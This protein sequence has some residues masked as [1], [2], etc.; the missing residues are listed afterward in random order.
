MV[1]HFGII[2]TSVHI[3]T[4]F[5]RYVFDL[6]SKSFKIAN[7]ASSVALNYVGLQ[8]NTSSTADIPSQ[9]RT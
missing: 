2:Q 4:Q 9:N 7:N 1:V 3:V 6:F 8:I 5:F